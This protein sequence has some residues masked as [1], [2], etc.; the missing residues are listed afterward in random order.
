ML[1]FTWKGVRFCKCWALTYPCLKDELCI[2]L[3]PHAQPL[4]ATEG[5]Y[6]I[7]KKPTGF[8]FYKYHIVVITTNVLIDIYVKS[9]F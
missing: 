3:V 6:Q 9:I 5:L 8:Y 4:D 2:L 1:L 7:R